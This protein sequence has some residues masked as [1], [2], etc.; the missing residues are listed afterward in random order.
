M[1]PAESSEEHC[2]LPTVC[3]LPPAK[4]LSQGKPKLKL[5]GI[6]YLLGTEGTEV[7]LGKHSIGC[8]YMCVAVH[9]CA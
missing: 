9:V 5:V 2:F 8:E 4:G 1:S 3:L 7:S 6:A